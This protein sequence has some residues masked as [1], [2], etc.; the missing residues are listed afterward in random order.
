MLTC[1]ACSRL[2]LYRTI[3]GPAARW[4]ERLHQ[5]PRTVKRRC[6]P[7]CC[8]AS[9]PCEMCTTVDVVCMEERSRLI[10]FQ[11]LLSKGFL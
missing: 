11:A 7:L 10:M 1:L 8:G 3:F 5:F 4:C 6:R 9:K 2:Q